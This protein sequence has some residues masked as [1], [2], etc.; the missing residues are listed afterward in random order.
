[1]SSTLTIKTTDNPTQTANMANSDVPAPRHSSR[2][3]NSA[4]ASNNMKNHKGVAPG[5]DA[6]VNNPP[7]TKRQR[8]DS[9]HDTEDGTHTPGPNTPATTNSGGTPAKLARPGGDSKG[10]SEG[11]SDG[12]AA[13]PALRGVDKKARAAWSAEAAALGYEAGTIKNSAYVLLAASGAS[14]M[15]VAAI[16]DAATKQGLYSWGTCKTP[17]N[18]VTAALSQDTTFVR[19]APS[20]YAL[21]STLKGAAG[22][23]PQA[24][25]SSGS[26]N[27]GAPTRSGSGLSGGAVAG[28]NAS[29]QNASSKARKREREAAAREAQLRGAVAMAGP[30]ADAAGLDV[31]AVAEMMEDEYDA[32]AP[33]MMGH[34][35]SYAVP[36]YGIHDRGMGGMGGETYE[37]TARSLAMESYRRRMDVCGGAVT[38]EAFAPLP[39]TRPDYDMEEATAGSCLLWYP[40]A[41]PAPEVFERPSPLKEPTEALM[42][43]TSWKDEAKAAMAGSPVTGGADREM[44]RLGSGHLPKWVLE[45]FNDSSIAAA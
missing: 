12:A 31:D 17:N 10:D 13:N 9:K 19:I 2:N 30:P 11:G 32:A 29:G 8:T 4:Y 25:T 39:M 21:R 24:R 44:S 22:P 37:H 33:M 28:R 34:G 26:I 1:M 20:T 38:C 36:K 15:T 23:V 7:A 14:G 35:V 16:V 27:S 41:N 18:S 45:S 5:G 43:A 40:T 6:W 3:V 42:R